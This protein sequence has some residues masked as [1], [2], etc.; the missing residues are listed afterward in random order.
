MMIPVFMEL[1]AYDATEVMR[2]QVNDS[3]GVIDLKPHY[4]G[5]MPPHELKYV[6]GK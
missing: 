3:A 2:L 6:P 4:F 1:Q 5:S